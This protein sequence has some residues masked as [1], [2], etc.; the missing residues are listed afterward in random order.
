M[1]IKTRVQKWGNSMALRI[2]KIIFSELGLMEHHVVELHVVD[3]ELRVRPVVPTKE[4]SLDEL[5]EGI[6]PQNLH[7]MIEVDGPRGKEIW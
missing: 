6:T 7:A 4:Y 5:V 3:N 1:T 2:P